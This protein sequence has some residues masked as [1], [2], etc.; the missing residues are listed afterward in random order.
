M[1]FGGN[2]VSMTRI[3]ISLPEDLLEDVDRLAEEQGLSRSEVFRR[4]AGGLLRGLA[5]R[6]A[7]RRYRAGY[8]NRPET[9]DD[10]ARARRSA[11]AALAVEPWE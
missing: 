10:V 9:S 5:E 11:V 3:A 2:F 7:A 4:A 6:D 1:N 8:R